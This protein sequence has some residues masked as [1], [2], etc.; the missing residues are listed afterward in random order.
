M[1]FF[2]AACFGRQGEHLLTSTVEEQKFFLDVNIT[3]Y[4]FLTDDVGN[5]V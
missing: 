5:S 2:S 3:G 4:S 1:L